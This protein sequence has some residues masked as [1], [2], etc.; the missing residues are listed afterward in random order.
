MGM[1]VYGRKPTAEVG[2][3]FRR[4]VWG[5]RPLA[6]LCIDL[7]PAIT[8]GCQHWHSNDGDGLDATLALSLACELR[9][10][11][12][13]GRAAS[14]VATRD[15][16]LKALPDE[17]C[18]ICGGTGVRTDKLGREMGQHTRRINEPSHPRHGKKGWCNGCDGRGTTRPSATWYYLDVSDVAEFT[19]FLEAC[20]GFEIH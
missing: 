2:E 14:Y 19:A 18:H 13:D 3:Y 5:W 1:D 20:G 7:A 8:A 6:D 10:A 16:A 9:A 17:T 11:L 4:N 12:A 15:T